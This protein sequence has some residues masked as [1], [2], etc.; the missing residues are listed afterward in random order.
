MLPTFGRF[1]AVEEIATTGPVT[2]YTARA[3]GEA[4]EPKF[5]V[6][7]IRTANELADPEILAARA[8]S[9]LRSAATLKAL[10]ASAPTLFAPVHDSGSTDEFAYFVTDFAPMTG[11]WLFDKRQPL[12]AAEVGKIVSAAAGAVSAARASKLTPALGSLRLTNILL[13]SRDVM[14]AKV[15]LTDPADPRLLTDSSPGDDMRAL[16]AM[17]FELIVHRSAPPSGT[18]IR[19]GA[20]WARLRGA[21]EPFR[22]LCEQLLSS[23]AAQSMLP[24]DVQERI[25]A[26][27][28]VKG[29]GA[30]LKIGLGVGG[31]LLVGVVL[32]IALHKSPPTP[33]PPTPPTVESYLEKKKPELKDKLSGI[34]GKL[35]GELGA[36]LA[37]KG[38][39]GEK[40]RD[41]LI[42]EFGSLD[43]KANTLF[44]KTDD[45]AN[46]PALN[47]E[48]QNLEKEIGAF[49]D[50]L[51]PAL[52]RAEA[53]SK[54]GTLNDVTDSLAT[55][56]AGFKANAAKFPEAN[57]AAAVKS[58]EDLD[59]AVATIRTDI[60]A[61]SD[62]MGTST[63][64][65]QPLATRTA[66]IESRLK[67]LKADCETW[68]GTYNGLNPTAA[69]LAAAI[70]KDKEAP[71]R[72]KA[73]LGDAMSVFYSWASES[74]SDDSDANAEQYAKYHEA[75]GLWLDAV[76]ALNAI[77]P[78]ANGQNLVAPDRLS[79]MVAAFKAKKVTD[80]CEELGKRPSAVGKKAIYA[81]KNRA[82]LANGEDIKP[83]RDVIT[84]GFQQLKSLLAAGSQLR[85]VI[86]DGYDFAEQPASG[87][88]MQTLAGT[89]R[90]GL[91]GDALSRFAPAKDQESDFPTAKK[92]LQ[93]V[94]D[95]LNALVTQAETVQ[96]IGMEST[97]AG[98]AAVIK[99]A[100]SS[101]TSKR[102]AWTRIAVPGVPATAA[103]FESLKP[104]YQAF[105]D[106]CGKAA[107]SAERQASIKAAAK[108]AM[109]D[110]WFDLVNKRLGADRPSVE[111]ALSDVNIKYLG[112]GDKEL[113]ERLVPQC[114]INLVRMA[115]EQNLKKT[116]PETSKLAKEAQI[117]ALSQTVVA[118]FS[119]ME[120]TA[121][122]DSVKDGAEYKAFASKL[123]WAREGKPGADFTREGP[124]KTGKWTFAADKSD[125]NRVVYTTTLTRSNSPADKLRAEPRLEFVKMRGSDD[126][127]SY[128][129]CTTELS[130]SGFL[131][132]LE[133]V[134]ERP[135]QKQKSPIGDLFPAK[136]E[137][138]DPRVGPRTWRYMDT[139][140][141]VIG[142]M[143]QATADGKDDKI[144]SHYWISFQKVPGI[145]NIN[146]FYPPGISVGF[147]TPNMPLAYIRPDAA[148]YIAAK[149]G[150]RLPTS[151]E[152]A[153][154]LQA[155]EPGDSNRRDATWKKQYDYIS[156]KNAEG[157]VQPGNHASVLP[158]ANI[159]IEANEKLPD[160]GA[161]AT[162][163]DDH[164]LWFAEVGIG[165]ATTIGPVELHHIYGNVAELV[166]DAPE[167]F[168]QI[169]TPSSASK[170]R[171]RESSFFV[172]GASALSPERYKPTDKL[173]VNWTSLKEG[174]TDL[175]MRLAF[176]AA[177]GAGGSGSPMDR[178]MSQLNEL[179]FVPT[180]GK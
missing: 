132:I 137:G 177:G 82:S 24:V 23:Q 90:E 143:Q 139:G 175:G 127:A 160:D 91:K 122:F 69:A 136:F 131:D 45:P 134:G 158:N 59:A 174:R 43:N 66:D 18:E 99:D 118:A 169:T 180:A 26:A 79:A 84:L 97:P 151:G 163:K 110:G 74:Y 2:V 170:L 159:F 172:M 147:A 179:N 162:S 49:S 111:T 29:G 140:E 146:P 16:G 109:V 88:T 130:V 3:A 123:K 176:T 50:S 126:S 68:K 54:V 14:E 11:H 92:E 89:V 76:D 100:N 144:A 141:Q 8:A 128:Y 108:K 32:Y 33:P 39:A 36:A 106:A 12:S 25:A 116:Q 73:P 21:G 101:F 60:K 153:A 57:K 61:I 83:S 53:A 35:Q 4:G 138:G 168:D 156:A 104:V 46:R 64:G 15:T 121:G 178:L 58:A 112:L 161:V 102:A 72:W 105:D 75:F 98:L 5:V 9:F 113:G 165:S 135:T 157:I 115:L 52:D 81:E 96:K 93:S 142:F 62:S 171:D 38:T 154:A 129:L 107:C 40:L 85:A 37:S 149:A 34:R 55:R 164:L 87:G 71:S 56:V 78:E 152:M 47:T 19:T 7:A 51:A 120:R 10:H 30:G 173:P 13:S 77:T 1:Q 94:T 48:T 65:G 119:D 133:A 95:E 20:E 80:I 155:A 31:A 67:K 117:A 27:L 44:A 6:K 86:V 63:A 148:V 41:D 167:I 114:K 103:D 125:D 28:E 145:D 166:C 70:K 42:K 124:A 150:C 22:K 17:M